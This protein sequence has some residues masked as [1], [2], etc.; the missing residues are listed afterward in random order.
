[1]DANAGTT[2]GPGDQRPLEPKRAPGR[3]PQTGG[4]IAMALER[5]KLKK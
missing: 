4:A 3:E 1:V 2:R 5:A